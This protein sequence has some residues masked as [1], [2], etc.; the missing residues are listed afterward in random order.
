MKVLDAKAKSSVFLCDKDDWGSALGMGRLN[1]V[2]PEHIVDL[3]FFEHSFIGPC[4]V[5]CT[6]DCCYAKIGE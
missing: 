2:Q 3:D 4:E 1:D 6:M 5:H